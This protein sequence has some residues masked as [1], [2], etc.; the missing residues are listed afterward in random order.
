M[1]MK[2]CDKESKKKEKE[3]NELEDAITAEHL[4]PRAPCRNRH[5]ADKNILTLIREIGAKENGCSE[6]R[7]KFPE[8]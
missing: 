2:E 1:L 3:M 6:V 5:M 4:G 7:E 8:S